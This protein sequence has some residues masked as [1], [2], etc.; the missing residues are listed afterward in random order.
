MIRTATLALAVLSVGFVGSA[1]ADTILNLGGDISNASGW[2]NGKPSSS[3]PG[4]ITVDGTSSS[5]TFGYGAGAI[6]THTAGDIVGP[7]NR[8]FNMN[9]GGTWNMSGGKLLFRYILSNGSNTIFNFSGGTAELSSTATTTQHMGVANGGKM[10][11]SGSAV[12]DGTQATTIVQATSGIIDIASGWTGSWTWGTYS[13]SDWKTIV[14]AGAG[15]NGFRLDGAI[16][17]SATFDA[18]FQVTPDGKTLSMIPEPA[19]MS[20]LAFG[21]L[22]VLARRR[23]NRA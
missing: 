8:G 12:L 3:N 9:G 17:S 6:I 1:G 11:I 14:T 2:N 5:D 22:G 20:L 23:R 4:T 10:N 18:T 19:T 16:I 7:G 13:G 15:S 21:G